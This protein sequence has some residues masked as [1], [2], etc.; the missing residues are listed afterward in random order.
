MVPQAAWRAA[1]APACCCELA[2]VRCS[3]AEDPAHAAAQNSGLGVWH[4]LVRAADV[5]QA[6]SAQ[7]RLHRA[8]KAAPS[9]SWATA[10]YSS[11]NA[12][13]FPNGR[14]TALGPARQEPQTVRF[15]LRDA[16]QPAQQDAPNF[17]GS[18]WHLDVPASILACP[19]TAATA[20]W[21]VRLADMKMRCA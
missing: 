15:I 18:L 12:V 17:A 2:S 11:G 13:I 9:T 21:A 1:G 16:T 14:L 8:V 19:A 6:L 20:R 4:P 10:E 5:R 7:G 3:G